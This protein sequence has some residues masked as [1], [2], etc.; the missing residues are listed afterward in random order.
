[1]PRSS[2]GRSRLYNAAL[3][4]RFAQRLGGRPRGFVPIETPLGSHWFEELLAYAYIGAGVCFSIGSVDFL[5]ASDQLGL[6]CY[7]YLLGGLIYFFT[8]LFDLE[9][10]YKAG[11]KY[12]EVA[13]NILYLIGSV[14]YFVSTFFYVPSIAPLFGDSANLLGSCGFI[15]GSA[16]FIVAC[17]LNGAHTG[18]AFSTKADAAPAKVVFWAKF[19]VLATTNTTNAGCIAFL[20][21]SV[22]YMPNIGCSE[23]TVVIGTYIFL[24]GSILFTIAGILPVI[25][26][27]YC[28]LAHWSDATAPSIREGGIGHL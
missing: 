18:E 14:L 28:N 9:E 12:F 24:L 3:A 20:V 23:P 10:A 19:L 26:R 11:S 2:N 13:M 16:F 21:G 27:K 15:A 6:G 17:F 8:T 7:L 22:L 4:L 25:R 1:M 5:P